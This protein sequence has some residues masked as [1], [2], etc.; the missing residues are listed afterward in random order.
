[1]LSAASEAGLS[2]LRMRPVV[3]RDGAAPLL[4]LFVLMRGLDLPPDQRAATWT[5]PALVIR[6]ASGAVHPEYSA[7]KLA[8]GFPP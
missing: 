5:E 3:L 7:I 1:M 2:I 4:G 8:F 6:T